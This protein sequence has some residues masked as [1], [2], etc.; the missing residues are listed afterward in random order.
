MPKVSASRTKRLQSRH[1]RRLSDL[2][3]GPPHLA[4]AVNLLV[5]DAV[6]RP[7]YRPGE[8]EQ[9]ALG[10]L[11]AGG[12]QVTLAERLRDPFELLALQLQEPRV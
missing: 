10:R 3:I 2:L 12:V 5:G 7:A 8:L 6:G 1:V 11:E 9:E 4:Q